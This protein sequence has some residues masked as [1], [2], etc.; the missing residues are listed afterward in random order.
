MKK[1]AQLAGSLV[2]ALSFPLAHADEDAIKKAL[3]TSMPT[4]K[5][6]SIKP[7]EI[8][9]VY[10]VVVGSSIYYVSEDG[11]YLLQGRLV[12]VANRIDLDREKTGRYPHSGFG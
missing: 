9:G 8:K 1:L 5:I 7:S 4:A 10:E 2:L 12:D 11:K 6:E 3:I